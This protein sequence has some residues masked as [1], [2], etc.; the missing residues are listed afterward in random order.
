MMQSFFAVSA[1]FLEEIVAE[2]VRALPGVQA[3]R[4]VPGGVEFSG[5]EA[6]L[7]RANLQLRCASRVLLRL[8]QFRARDFSAL[9]RGIRAQSWR[10][11][12]VG[13]TRVTVRATAHR[14]RLYHTGAII[15]R[16]VDTLAELGIHAPTDAQDPGELSILVRAEDD[17]FTVSI[18]TS[19]ELLH[20]RGWRSEGGEAPLRETL[21]AALLRLSAWTGDA[22]LCDPTCGSGT[23]LIEAA[24]LACGRAPGLLRRFAFQGFPR[25]RD[26][27]YRRVVSDVQKAERRVATLLLCGSDIS[28]EAVALSRRNAERA[29]IAELLR[30]DCQ[31]VAKAHLPK[32]PAGL[33]LCNPPYGKR[34]QGPRLRNL[35]RA[36]GKYAES[37]PGWRLGLLCPD[38][39][40]GRAASRK[41]M[42][43]AKRLINGGLRVALYLSAE[44]ADAPQ[45]AYAE[46]MEKRRGHELGRG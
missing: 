44:L 19:G 5:D 32:G 42:G 21:G 4:L 25:Y 41:F 12:A 40:L 34:I 31:D 38:P 8:G 39:L 6:V 23:L 28:A 11:Y 18:D 2:E 7:Y 24:L 17:V 15:E 14:S 3:V 45:H 13:P 30:I 20:R 36:I 33:V 26:A 43:P 9:V 29:G 16:V 35:Y 1:P 27:L 10:E 37:A 46:D 22:P